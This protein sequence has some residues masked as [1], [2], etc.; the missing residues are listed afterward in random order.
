MEDDFV[1]CPD[2][3]A[4]IIDEEGGI[5]SFK[6][7]MDLVLNYSSFGFYSSGKINISRKGDFVT[8]PTLGSDFSELLTI[9]LIDWIKQL[10]EEANDLY[11]ISLIE[12]GPGEGDLIADI[13][14]TIY[15]L[16]PEVIEYIEIILVEINHGMYLKQKEKL[17]SYDSISIIWANIEDIVDKPVYGVVIAHEI[18]DALPVERLIYKDNTFHREAV[19]L[20]NI[21]N[22]YYIY[23]TI[24]PMYKSLTDSI[25]EVKIRYSFEFPP[26]NTSEVWKTEW[27]ISLKPWFEKISESMKKGCLVIIDYTLDAK[28]YYTK[29]RFDGTLIN[30]SKQ[31]TSNN[32]LNNPGDSDLTSHI[33]IETL[34]YY[35]EASNW[36]FKGKVKQ[37]EALL[38]L[39]LAQK[40]YELREVSMLN[41]ALA[42]SKRE[43]LLRLVDPRCLGNF[44]WLVFEI[45]NLD[46]SRL[47]LR[48]KCLDEPIKDY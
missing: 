4:Q 5:I 26:K 30:Y 12:F 35:A 38:S 17:K 18:L 8:S 25:N 47:N 42:L 41:P 48:S 29:D 3:L 2:W 20:I 40:I 11:K 24:L 43:S 32:I 10:K 15:S 31:S 44:D 14:S 7:Y 1:K 34:K 45:N 22:Q 19:K 16:A 36:L 46:S 21:N 23:L 39:G 6:R 9:Q 27:H 28:R 37:G 13:I 33:C